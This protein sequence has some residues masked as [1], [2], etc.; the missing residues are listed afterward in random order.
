MAILAQWGWK[1]APEKAEYPLARII[2]SR[3]HHR[4]KER[5][6]PE[7]IEPGFLKLGFKLWAQIFEHLPYL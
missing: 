1:E 6:N 3:I 7:I 2:P 5:G 4:Q